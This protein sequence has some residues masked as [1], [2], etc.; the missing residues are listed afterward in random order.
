MHGYITPHRPLAGGVCTLDIDRV[1]VSLRDLRRDCMS[2][3]ADRHWDSETD[4][5]VIG[6]GAAGMTAALVGTLEGLRVVICEKSEMVGGTTAT[7]AGSSGF[8][9]AARA[10]RPACP[11]RSRRRRP[12]SP[13]C[14]ATTRST[15]GCWPVGLRT[16]GPDGFLERR[17]S[18][19]FR[20]RRSILTTGICRARQSADARSA[21]SHSTAGSSVPTSRA[22]VRPSRIHGPRRHDDRQK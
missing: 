12:I 17:T 6:A 19:G 15:N 5:L 8:P 21:R 1:F 22:C 16:G 13:A 11:N 3:S 2:S 9:A 18:V 14:W 4:L 7:S 10:K 20:H